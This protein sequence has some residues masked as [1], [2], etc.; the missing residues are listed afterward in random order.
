MITWAKGLAYRL[1]LWAL[2]TVG[3][4]VLAVIR[5]RW[6]ESRVERHNRLENERGTEA[7]DIIN[8]IDLER[9]GIIIEGIVSNT[10]GGEARDISTVVLQTATKH[11]KGIARRVAKECVKM[12]KHGCSARQVAK[13][14]RRRAVQCARSLG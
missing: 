12:A 4:A 13:H 3:N 11:E 2:V 10:M 8:G 9:V 5:S 7:G 6:L 1:W 14:A